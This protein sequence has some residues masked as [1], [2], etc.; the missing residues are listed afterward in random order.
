MTYQPVDLVISRDISDFT[1]EKRRAL[2]RKFL[3][4][5]PTW[6]PSEVRIV[7]N[8]S[9]LGDE[10]ITQRISI[11][12]LGVLSQFYRFQELRGEINLFSTDTTDVTSRD[13]HFVDVNAPMSDEIRQ[14]LENIPEILITR[15]DAGKR[16]RVIVSY[17]EGNGL[18]DYR[19]S[20]VSVVTFL[21][22]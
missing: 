7:V 6:A 17:D 3:A 8:E 14:R 15:L 22:I 20:P 9:H 5:I 18:N 16:L 2:R 10:I 4:E 11:I 19:Y 1:P 21:L 12:P 13:F